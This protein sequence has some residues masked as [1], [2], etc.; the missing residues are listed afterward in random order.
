VV[1]GELAVRPRL[2]LV[3]TG[4]H[5]LVDGAHAGTVITELRRLLAEPDLLDHP[6]QPPA[7]AR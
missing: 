2:V 6:A 5:R 4:D 3:A 1:N 7:D